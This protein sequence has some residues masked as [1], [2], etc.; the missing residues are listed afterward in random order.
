MN[1]EANKIDA[2]DE[3]VALEL[4]EVG[5]AFLVHLA[6]ENI[7]TLNALL[8]GM[9]NDDFEGHFGRPKVPVGIG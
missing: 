8:G 2:V 6:M 7:D 9:I 5:G 3:S 1:G 4:L